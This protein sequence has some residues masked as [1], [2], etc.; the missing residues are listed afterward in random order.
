MANLS[1][2]TG[3]DLPASTMSLSGDTSGILTRTVSPV[4]TLAA[5]SLNHSKAGCDL[6]DSESIAKRGES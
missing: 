3:L 1:E 6:V 5:Q 2:I 4:V